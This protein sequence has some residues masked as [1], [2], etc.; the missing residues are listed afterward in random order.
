MN[1]VDTQERP[2]CP[3]QFFPIHPSHE[4]HLKL[5]DAAIAAMD[6]DQYGKPVQ[7][8]Q[9]LEQQRVYNAIVHNEQYDGRMNL[10]TMQV[11]YDAG[12]ASIEAWFFR[13]GVC[14]LIIAANRVG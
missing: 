14:G 12:F 13:C 9:Q 6:K 4:L 10:Y 2:I 1:Y 5:R 11:G 3:N 7:L 8:E